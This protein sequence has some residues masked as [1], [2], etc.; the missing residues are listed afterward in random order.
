MGLEILQRY[1]LLAKLV[2]PL[3]RWDARQKFRR[4]EAFLSPEDTLLEVGSGLGSVT[5]YF[6]EKGLNVTPLD[7]QDL[8]LIPQTKPLIYDGRRIPFDDNIFTGVLLLTVLHHTQEPITILQEAKRLT[9]RIII[10]EDIYTNKWQ[11][12][13]TYTVDSLVNLEGKEHPHNNHTDAE[14]REIFRALDLEIIYSY[15]Y[16]FLGLFRQVV[17]VLKI[18]G[19]RI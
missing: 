6:R 8:S 18:F 17:Y 7:I 9:P 14:W 10:I 12:Y 2:L 19:D 1:P 11:K 3:W 5:G 16:P 13:L 15:D 4:L